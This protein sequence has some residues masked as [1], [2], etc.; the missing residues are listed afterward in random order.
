MCDFETDTH[1]GVHQ[2]N[3]VEV[4]VLKIGD[5]GATHDYEKRLKTSFGINGYGCDVKFCDWLFS[6]ENCNS[7][8]IAHNGAG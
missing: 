8:V 4:D 2:P 3:H 7:S 1:T 5:R 6:D